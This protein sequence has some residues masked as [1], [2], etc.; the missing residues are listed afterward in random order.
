M[1][2]RDDNDN[3]AVINDLLSVRVQ[4]TPICVDEAM[5]EIND[6]RANLKA[7]E[8]SYEKNKQSKR[9]DE[10]T[11]EISNK[12]KELPR[13]DESMALLEKISRMIPYEPVVHE[14][15]AIKSK[16][17]LENLPD[18]IVLGARSTKNNNQTNKVIYNKRDKKFYR[19]DQTNPTCYDSLNQAYTSLFTGMKG[20]AWERFKAYEIRGNGKSPIDTLDNINLLANNSDIYCDKTFGFPDNV[21]NI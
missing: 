6:L 11:N 9:F 20:N 15:V 12:I 1:I 5:R 14:P 4:Q 19:Y 13:T 16:Y 18:R 2:G 8:E 7:M 17:R 3:A 10:I 21:I